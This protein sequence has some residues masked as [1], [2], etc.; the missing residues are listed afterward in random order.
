MKIVIDNGGLVTDEV[1]L[2][3]VLQ[4]LGRDDGTVKFSDGYAVEIRTGKTQKTFKVVKQP[5]K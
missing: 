4:V 5:E 1:A 2:R 3:M